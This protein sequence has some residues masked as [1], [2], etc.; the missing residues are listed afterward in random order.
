MEN[1]EYLPPVDVTPIF[2]TIAPAYLADRKVFE[3]EWNRQKLQNHMDNLRNLTGWYHGT[4]F[5][6]GV[7]RG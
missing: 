2:E 3:I 1:Y 7:A 4:W 5:E 6:N